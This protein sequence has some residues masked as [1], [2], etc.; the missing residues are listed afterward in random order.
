MSKRIGPEARIITLFDS[1]TD[2]GKRIVLDLI[3]SK[4]A[5]PVVRKPRADKGTTRK[6]KE[7][8]ANGQTNLTN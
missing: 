7:D 5:K 3:K 1:L 8:A 6:T 2:D 4:Q